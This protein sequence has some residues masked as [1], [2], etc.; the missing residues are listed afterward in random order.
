ML[1][2]LGEVTVT[3]LIQ[4]LGFPLMVIGLFVLVLCT[5]NGSAAIVSRLIKIHKTLEDISEKLGQGRP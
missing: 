2:C 5:V 1:V 3:E 4:N